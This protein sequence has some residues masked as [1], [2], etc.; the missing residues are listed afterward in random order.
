MTADQLRALALC[1]ESGEDADILGH[2]ALA[3]GWTYPHWLDG[4]MYAFPLSDDMPR[5]LPDWLNSLDAA[6]SLVPA[7]LWWSVD[8]DGV[9]KAT[10]L[11]NRSGVFS[12]GAE[13]P[14]PARALTAAALR[15]CAALAEMEARDA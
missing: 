1:V 3:I 15:A 13:G 14:T 11:I 5:P 7:C 9:G 2:I 8:C 6:A 12:E 4:L 10:A